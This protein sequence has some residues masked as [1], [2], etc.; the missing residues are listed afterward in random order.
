MRGGRSGSSPG[1]QRWPSLGQSDYSKVGTRAKAIIDRPRRH[2]LLAV[3]CAVL[4]QRA[5]KIAF[6]KIPSF[7][8]VGNPVTDIDVWFKKV[9]Y[10]S[11]IAEHG[12][13][14]RSNLHEADLAN[15]ADPVGVIPALDRRD[16]IC[17]G[18]GKASA[19]GLTN[20]SGK[21]K[22]PPRQSDGLLSFRT[23]LCSGQRTRRRSSYHGGGFDHH[24]GSF[25][26]RC[27]KRNEKYREYRDR[28]Y[29]SGPRHFAF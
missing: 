13:R 14:L 6:C 20:D 4:H 23:C 26:A 19:L 22:C 1:C 15:A 3:T 7:R 24:V 29:Q 2:V 10:R 27:R 12:G 5:T 25:R 17:D 8:K 28:L 21:I 18:G 16:G 9:R 11:F